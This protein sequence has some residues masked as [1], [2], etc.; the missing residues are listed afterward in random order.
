MGLTQELLHTERMYLSGCHLIQLLRV[1]V[2]WLELVGFTYFLDISI[3]SV[4]K[5]FEWV[6]AAMQDLMQAAKSLQ[7]SWLMCGLLPASLHNIKPVYCSRVTSIAWHCTPKVWANFHMAET[8]EL[9]KSVWFFRAYSW[10]PPYVWLNF[11]HRFYFFSQGFHSLLCTVRA[12]D[13]RGQQE[14]AK[15][16]S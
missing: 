13:S 12:W 7:A 6:T 15:T 1:K 3:F 2:M 14:K 16:V 9:L 10:L 11:K 4:L 8:S 5:T